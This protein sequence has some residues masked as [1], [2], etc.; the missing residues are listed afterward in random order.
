LLVAVLTMNSLM[1]SVCICTGL[2][3]FREKFGSWIRPTRECTHP[4]DRIKQLQR[5]MTVFQILT[6]ISYSYS[7]PPNMRVFSRDWTDW[8]FSIACF[9]GMSAQLLMEIMLGVSAQMLVM[10]DTERDIANDIGDAIKHHHDEIKNLRDQLNISQEALLHERFKNTKAVNEPNEDKKHIV[11]LERRIL[12]D[13]FLIDSLYT[14]L[15]TA[16]EKE[17]EKKEFLK[18]LREKIE[19]NTDGFGEGDYLTMMELLKK[20]YE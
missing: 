3:I 19:D 17:K 4:D 5:V 20:L 12:S 11:E 2:S 9:S 1:T 13:R 6:V 10:Y 14:R 18:E 8:G 16:T 7:R 15:N